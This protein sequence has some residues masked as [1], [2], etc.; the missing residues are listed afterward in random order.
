[1]FVVYCFFLPLSHTGK[2]RF[3]L[4]KRSSNS[5]K[6]DRSI[7]EN[8]NKVCH[9]YDMCFRS[10]KDEVKTDILIGLGCH[11]ALVSKMWHFLWLTL[12]LDVEKIVLAAAAAATATAKLPSEKPGSSGVGGSLNRASSQESESLFSMLNMCCQTTQ[13]CLV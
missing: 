9:L 2:I 13:Y 5:I 8:A 7:L 3:S 6:L 4:F 12:G 11:G 10:L 1:M